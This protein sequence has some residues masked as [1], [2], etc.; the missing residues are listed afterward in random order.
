MFGSIPI[1]SIIILLPLMG[2]I[3]TFCLGRYEKY[4]KWVALSF[5]LAALVLSV[6]VA[7][8]FMVEPDGSATGYHEGNGFFDFQ[9]YEEYSWI[10]SLGIRY[11]VRLDGRGLTR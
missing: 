5:S 3:A 8:D 6:L 11:I 2:A 1:I 4:A 9:Y 7:V 10:Q